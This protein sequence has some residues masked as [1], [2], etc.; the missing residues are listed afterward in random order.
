MDLKTDLLYDERRNGIVSI[1]SSNTYVLKAAMKEALENDYPALIEATANQ[2]NQFGGYTGMT[3]AMFRDYVH[4]LA[5]KIGLNKDKI[6]LGGDHLGPLIW[7]DLP[8]TEAMRLAE[9]L[10]IEYVSAGFKKIHIDTTMKLADDKLNHKLDDQTIARRAVRLISAC[11]KV[12]SGSLVYVIGSEVPIPGGATSSS[13][14]IQLTSV[15]NLVEQLRL[16]RSELSKSGLDRVLSD[17]VAVVVQP[18]VEFG[19]DEVIEYDSDAAHNL[20]DF[21]IT[22]GSLS[23]EG[24]ST[25]YQLKEMLRQMVDDGVRILKVGPALT[26][27]FRQAIYGLENI[28]REFEFDQYSR[29]KDTYEKVMIAHPEKWVN[30]YYGNESELHIKRHYSYCDRIRYYANYSEVEKATIKLIDN[31]SNIK[32]PLSMVSDY[33]PNQYTRIRKGEIELDPEEIII[34]RIRDWIKDYIY[35]VTKEKE[36]ENV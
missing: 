13:G 27:A 3:P 17:V 25:D 30:Y 6:V 23:F 2:V 11:E 5:A 35:A 31:L 16:F 34:D 14:E 28:E 4:E 33:F 18:G 7:Q 36:N 12:R 22:Q 26:F 8:E 19:D 24:H 15:S 10:V 20:H 21:L 32:I 9:D 1:C 29:I